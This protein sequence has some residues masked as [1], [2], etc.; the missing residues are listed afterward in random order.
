MKL[1]NQ[2]ERICVM[3]ER[4]KKNAFTLQSFQE[5]ATKL[6]FKIIL[7]L[8]DTLRVADFIKRKK[9]PNSKKSKIKNEQK[10]ENDFYWHGIQRM[11]SCTWN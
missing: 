1:I 2:I 3:R 6:S 9:E 8:S 10:T 5:V 4:R 7:E 11:L